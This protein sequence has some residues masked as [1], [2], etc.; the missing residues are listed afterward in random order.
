MQ[1]K[2]RNRITRKIRNHF[3]KIATN[4]IQIYV[5]IF[6]QNRFSNNSKRKKNEKKTQRNK[7]NTLNNKIKKI[8]FHT[9]IYTFEFDIY[10]NF[11]SNE[12]TNCRF[13]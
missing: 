10:T 6:I 8:K 11:E 12:N 9:L 4:H 5:E 2:Q 13:C 7:I 3:V 1:S